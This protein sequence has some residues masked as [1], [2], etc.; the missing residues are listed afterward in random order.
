MEEQRLVVPSL[1]IIHR[2]QQRAVRLV[3]LLAEEQRLAVVIPAVVIPAVVAADMDRHQVTPTEQMLV[4]KHGHKVAVAV[5]SLLPPEVAI[6]VLV[7]LVPDNYGMIHQIRQITTN[8]SVVE[9]ALLA[10][11]VPHQMMDMV[12]KVS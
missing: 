11:L 7:V 6:P 1:V 5:A 3:P 4:I 9:E 2:Q 8:S 12:E 10:Q